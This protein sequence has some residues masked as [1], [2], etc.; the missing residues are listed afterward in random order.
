VT[1]GDGWIA[2]VTADAAGH[3]RIRVLDRATGAERAV[4]EIVPAP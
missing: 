1:L 3:E 2:V 4:T